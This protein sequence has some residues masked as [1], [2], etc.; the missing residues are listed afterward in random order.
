MWRRWTKEYVRTLRKRHNLKHDT[1]PFSLG[2]GDV[3]IIYAE[4]RNRGKWP[5]GIVQKFYKERDGVIRAAKIKTVNGHLER[6]VRQL[7]PLELSCDFSPSPIGDKLNPEAPVFRPR[8]E[9]AAVVRL[10]IKQ[11]VIND[12]ND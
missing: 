12:E 9:A 1:K 11:Q 3:V 4:E 2:V 8:R 5:L 7:Y 6:P 10:R